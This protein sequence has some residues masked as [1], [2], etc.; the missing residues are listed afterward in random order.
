MI[1]FFAR[2]KITFQIGQPL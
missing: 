1:Y 2:F